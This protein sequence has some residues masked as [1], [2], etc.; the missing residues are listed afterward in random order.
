MQAYRRFVSEGRGAS[1]PWD[2]LKR[3]VYLG[4]EAF[5]D[6]AL[7]RLDVDAPWIE[8]PSTQHRPPPKPLAHYAKTIR[9][10]DAA[11]AAAYASGGYSMKVI[12][13]HFGLHYSMVSRLVKKMADSRFKT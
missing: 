13:D 9:D 10:R 5:V 3:Q 6:T 2:E 7:A 12:G 11:I 4:D 1:S 8:V